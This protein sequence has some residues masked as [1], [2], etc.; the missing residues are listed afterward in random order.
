[1]IRRQTTVGMF[2][3]AF[4]LAIATHAA[5]VP[6]TVANPSF[7][8]PV[9]TDGQFTQGAGI[10]GWTAPGNQGVWNPSASQVALVPDGL[11]IGFSNGGTV[12]QVLGD[13]LAA[14]TA[15]T[16]EVDALRRIDGCCGNPTFT[17]ELLAGSTVLDSESLDYTLLAPGAIVTLTAAFATGAAHPALGQPLSIR[18][19]SLGQQ[20]DFDDVRLDATAVNGA[21]LE[22]ASL[23]L[24]ASGL[25]GLAATVR[26]RR[27]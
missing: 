19:T 13:V 7:E 3:G 21:V 17:I 11:Q 15:Y 18:L 16:L 1:M 26:K 8:T 27:S 24:L 2:V 20:S 22:P 23:V 25:V 12:S 6:I 14:D 4:V 10:P 5:A 9:L